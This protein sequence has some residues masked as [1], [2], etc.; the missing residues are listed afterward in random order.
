MKKRPITA[1]K[2]RSLIVDGF[3][4]GGGASLGIKL[5]TGRSPD[6]AVNHDAASIR[7]HEANHPETLHVLEDIWKAR[8]RELVGGRPV[9]LLW[10]SPDCKHFS[11]AKGAKPVS[12]H[13]RSLAW[14]AC[15][16]AKQ[17]RPAVIILENVREFEDWGPL[18]PQWEC[19]SCEWRGTEGQTT[20]ARSRRRCPACDSVRIDPTMRSVP[21]PGK[22]GWT[23]RRFVGRLRA[24]GYNVQWKTLNAADYGAPTH[25]RR[26]FLVARCD[27]LPITWPDAT[28]TSPEKAGADLFGETKPW[29]TAAECI[30]WS[31]PCP[32]IFERKKELAPAT[33]RRIALGFKRYVL[34]NPRPYIVRCAHGA[35][36]RW[37][38][39]TQNPD[40]PLPTITG[41][42]DCAV[43]GVTVA[44]V[45]HKGER[46]CPSVEEPLATI[47]TA[48]R[49]EQM[50]V[51]AHVSRQF[52]GSVGSDLECPLPTTTA[53]GGGK[54]A[55]VAAFMAKHFGGV[56]GV[57]IDTPLPTTTAIATQNQI[58][59]A[60]LVH[61]NHGAK[62]WSGCDEPLRT[63]TTANHAALVYAFLVRYFGTA[64]GQHCT[65]PLFT[66]TGKD[67]FGL[68]V[69]EIRGEPY[70]VVD[71]G[72]RMLRPRE[73]ARAQ[74]F[75]EQ[76]VLTGN[77]TEQV[78]RIGN[79][80][81]PQVAAAIVAANCLPLL[82][83]AA[84]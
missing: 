62:Q 43:V 83:A 23:F 36:G 15:R 75:P 13:I 39:G 44:P 12:K 67:R 24:L 31:I 79:S 35:N 52:G 41:S 64:I 74:G 71:I 55:L 20:L 72:M 49:G 77:K 14:V 27:G 25:R 46:R 65:E 63:Q 7:M 70:V 19:K 18:L 42:N 81:C 56:V 1:W 40:V 51:T 48:K 45:T 32:S 5:A 3:A 84:V 82:Q 58:V 68:I 29:R 76:Y 53:G 6:I 66:V 60:N 8:L 50:V 61:L 4:G 54:S 21:D 17:V 69:V 47:T 30:D 80:V 2:G 22:K 28:H 57:N 73:L 37:G 9:G 10:L 34:E 16:W 11:R 26:L 59:A 33:L 78:G 38:D